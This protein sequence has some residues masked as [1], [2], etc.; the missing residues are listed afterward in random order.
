MGRDIQISCDDEMDHAGVEFLD[1]TFN[2]SGT[3]ASAFKG[4]LEFAEH[5]F[6]APAGIIE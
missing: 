2:C 3:D 5:S 1:D 6:D 4:A